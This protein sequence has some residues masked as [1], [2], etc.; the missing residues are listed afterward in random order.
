MNFTN[1][2]VYQIYPKS[3]YD[4]NGDGIGDLNG[5][6]MKLDYIKELGADM[7]W[8][9][10]FFCSPQKDNGYDISDY[11]NIEPMY[12][13]MTDFEEMVRKADSLGIGIMLD[14]V[15]NH[16]STE[17][18]W[19]KKA[20]SGDKKYIDYY[21][22]RDSSPDTPPTNWQSKFGGSAWEYV[23][24]LKKW[25]LHLFDKTQADLNWENPKVRKELKNVLRFW[26]GKGVKGFRFDV[27]NLVSKP[28]K[29][30]NDYIGDGRRF[31][32]DGPKI[33][34][35]LKELHRDGGLDDVVTVGEMSSTSLENCIGYTNPKE[36]ELNMSFSFHH[37]KV[38]YFNGDKWKLQPTDY[39]KLK[40]ILESWQTKMAENNGW[41]ALFWC[42][43]DQPRTVSRFGDT[44]EFHKESAKMLATLMYLMRGTPYIYQGEELGLENAGFKNISQYRD[45]ESLNYFEILKSQG[46]SEQDALYIISQRS[47]DNGRTPMQW[48]NGENAGFSSVT[49]WIGLSENSKGICAENEIKD[50]NSVFNYFKKL[51]ALRKTNK[52]IS[53]GDIDFFYSDRE[54]LFC[55]KRSLDG[56]QIVVICNMTKNEVH[57]DFTKYLKG[58]DMI[59]CNY[60]DCNCQNNEIL[61][62][63]EAAVYEK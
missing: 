2:T 35:F 53:D 37:L 42:N 58:M 8:I 48:T 41:N 23:P 18:Q 22:F 12:G 56:K 54:D 62:P 28:Q 49:P 16:T 15:F 6:T 51:I 57:A 25:Y 60:N 50:E 32:T 26:K 33:H 10:P 30:E 46:I 45:V 24:E 21:I 13:T 61:R 5:I 39:R 34:E 29:F 19:F 44:K 7:I 55:Y 38:D 20:L 40:D 4:S 17:H 9:T 43:H 47:R 1:S 63:Y 27:I 59:L 52:V 3:F 14:M 36:K 11:L 31:Y